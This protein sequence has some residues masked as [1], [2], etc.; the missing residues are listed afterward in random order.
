MFFFACVLPVDSHDSEPPASTCEDLAIPDESGGPDPCDVAACETCADSCA[1]PCMILESYPPQYACEGAGSWSVYDVCPDW[2]MPGG[3]YAI[4]EQELGCGDG[5]QVET[6]TATPAG[7]GR[8]EVDH[9]DAGSGCCPESLA[10]EVSAD[11]GVLRVAYDFVNDFCEC[12]CL[13]DVSYTQV[14]VP[15]GSWTLV[16]GDN[17]L[18]TTVVVE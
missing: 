11:D 8:I 12:E 5:T 14:E 1:E 2:Q 15:A 17:G 6:L 7:A 18:S 3:P 13:L 16:A 4:D 9:V 10:V